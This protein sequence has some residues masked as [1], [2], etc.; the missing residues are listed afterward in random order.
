MKRATNALMSSVMLAAACS[1]PPPEPDPEDIQRARRAANSFEAR[2]QQTILNRLEREPPETVHLLYRNR[3]PAMI[4]EI[5][6]E[7]DVTFKRTALR[8]RNR[9][10]AADDWEYEKLEALT[11]SME[12]GLD[13][14]LLEFAEV[15]EDDN[16]QHMFRWIRPIVMSETCL[17]CH[18]EEVAVE[19]LDLL[20]AEYPDD[21]ATGYFEYELGGAY[22]VIRPVE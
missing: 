10:N 6:E 2:L 15:V 22:S 1:A 19:V 18:G 11:F 20:A 13:P 16:G 9:N 3:V 4:A 17:V 5:S 8:V 14:G 21:E 7:H 12:A